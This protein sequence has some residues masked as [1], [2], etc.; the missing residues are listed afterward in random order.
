MSDISKNADKYYFAKYIV[1]FSAGMSV[2]TEVKILVKNKQ[3][4]DLQC[5]NCLKTIT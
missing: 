3:F 5:E 4:K 1:F 2:Q